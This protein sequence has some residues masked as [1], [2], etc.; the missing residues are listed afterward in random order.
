MATPILDNH[1]HLLPGKGKGIDAVR[2]FARSGGTHMLIVNQPSWKL[3]ITVDAPTDFEAVFEA[4]LAVVERASE[5][6]PGRA[7]PV[8]GVHPALI[9][10]LIEDQA[11]SPD[12]AADLMCAGLTIAAEYAANGPAVALKSGRPHYE[13]EDAVWAAS[14]TVI[15]HALQ[16]AAE[17]GVAVQLHTEAT[18]DLTEVAAWAEAAGLPP[19]QVVKHYASGACIGVT[20]SVISRE[21]AL[22]TAA[23]RA[24]PFLMETDFLDDPDRPGAV[25]GPRTV[26]RRTAWLREHDYEEAVQRAHVETPQRVYGIDTRL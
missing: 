26:P 23:E 5:E 18:E 17:T 14:N 9:S 8:L 24:D 11:L 20:A 1:L 13:V 3:D 7:W 15:K 12:A 22:Q 4:T 21:E 10:R 2:E 6:L 25:L 16:L 19:E